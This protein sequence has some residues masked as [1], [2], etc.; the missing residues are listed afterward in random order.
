M[1]TGLRTALVDFFLLVLV[2]LVFDFNRDDLVLRVDRTDFF[3]RSLFDLSASNAALL[4]PLALVRAKG[5]RFWDRGRRNLVVLPLFFQ[6]SSLPLPLPL[7]SCPRVNVHLISLGT[8]MAAQRRRK[9]CRGSSAQIYLFPLRLAC[10]TIPE[11]I[12]A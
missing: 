3:F 11:V 10:H 8:L 6:K 4:A 9:N 2:F 5:T 1:I 12:R 7:P